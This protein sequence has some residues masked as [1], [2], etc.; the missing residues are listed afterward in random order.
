M[1]RVTILDPTSTSPGQ[2]QPT[3]TK[4]LTKPGCGG[5]GGVIVLTQAV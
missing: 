2:A 1:S 3:Q 5:I 4:L